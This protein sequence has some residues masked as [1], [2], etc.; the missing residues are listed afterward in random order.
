MT[1]VR[2]EWADIDI[3]LGKLIH[4]LAYSAGKISNISDHIW[5]IDYFPFLS[6]CSRIG[7]HLW[8]HGRLINSFF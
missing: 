2:P 7:F 4:L 5:P 1:N 8:V 3:L 6:S